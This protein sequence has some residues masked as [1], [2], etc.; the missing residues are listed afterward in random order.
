M[1][2]YCEWGLPKPVAD[3]YTEAL[4][5]LG[6]YKHPLHYAAAHTVW[7]DYNFSDKS[8]QWCIDNFNKYR[9]DYTDSELRVVMWSLLKLLQIPE[10]ERDIASFNNEG[11]ELIDAPPPD[12]IKMVKINE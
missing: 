7:D 3:I 1:C 6:G 8:I 9:G 4:E 10:N 2:W 12:G 11:E 5:K